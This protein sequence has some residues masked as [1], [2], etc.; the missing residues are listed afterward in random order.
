MSITRVRILYVLRRLAQ[1]IPVIFIIV[2]LN[3]LLVHLAHGSPADAL[4]GSSGS[5]TP[6]YMALLRHEFGLDK[7]LYVQYFDYLKNVFSLN[8]GYSFFNNMP[9]L[10]LI[11][12]RLP[13]T[14]LLMGS[15]I[16]LSVGGGI[17]LGLFAGERPNSTRDRVISFLSLVLYATP[18]FWL[19]LMLIILFALRL[20]WFPASGMENVAQFYTGWQMVVD[21]LHHLLLP[22]VTLST[23]YL[24]LYARLMRA[25][26]LEHSNMEYVVTAYSKG[27]TQRAVT[28][29]HILQNACLPVVTMAGVQIANLLGGSVVVESVF[30]WPGIGQLA[31]QALVSRDLN[32]LLAIFFVAACLVMVVNLIVDVIYTVLDPRIELA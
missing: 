18:L 32:L 5:A 21:V 20:R 22:A 13:A 27:L 29:K 14:L 8:L 1:A 28:F 23:F 9:V 12:Q 2:S 10:A 31:F 25:S 17:I 15:T 4:A 19:G 30:G 11:L 24:A 16:I 7:P 3:F 6:E 26:M